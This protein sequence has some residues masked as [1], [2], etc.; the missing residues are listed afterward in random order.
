VL[1]S[2]SKYGSTPANRLWQAAARAER[3]CD[4]LARKN[5]AKAPLPR[6][7]K[8]QKIMSNKDNHRLHRTRRKTNKEPNSGIQSHIIVTL[9]LCL[10]SACWLCTQIDNSNSK[11]QQQQAATSSL[12]EHIT[13]HHQLPWLTANVTRQISGASTP[14]R[15]PQYFWQLH[16]KPALAL[17][18]SRPQPY[19]QVRWPLHGEAEHLPPNDTELGDNTDYQ[20]KSNPYMVVLYEGSFFGKT[21]PTHR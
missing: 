18:G 2:P 5:Q 6:C 13:A 9:P 4:T 7:D 3:R 1:Y 10:V 21:W 14:V 15:N 12:P 20:N 8:E 17:S 16:D 19:P 11:H